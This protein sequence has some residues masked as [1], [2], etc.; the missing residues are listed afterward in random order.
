VAISSAGS[1]AAAAGA[2]Q[3]LCRYSQEPY[4]GSPPV[5]EHQHVQED[6]YWNEIY[7]RSY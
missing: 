6:A 7:V 3:D 5:A 4:E 1:A 2:V